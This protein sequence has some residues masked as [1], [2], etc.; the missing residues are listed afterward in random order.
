MVLAWFFLSAVGFEGHGELVEV[1]VLVEENAG[2]VGVTDED[3]PALLLE[4]GEAH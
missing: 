1:E 2:G 4:E 3:V